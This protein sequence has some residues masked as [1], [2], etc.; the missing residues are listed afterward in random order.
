M[1]E[2]HTGPKPHMEQ[3]HPKHNHDALKEE[4]VSASHAE[5]VQAK[6]LET[7]STGKFG[8]NPGSTTQVKLPV[9]LNGNNDANSGNPASFV[10][11]NAQ[12]TPAIAEDLDLIEREWVHKAKEIVEETK[13]DPYKQAAE[14]NKMKADYLKK[15]YNIEIKL[16]EDN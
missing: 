16:A 9:A 11:Q 7:A 12:G 1:K 4:S 3:R 14:M 6:A 10:I 13:D 5:I 2:R 15:R 8:P